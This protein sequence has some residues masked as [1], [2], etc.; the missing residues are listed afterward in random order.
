MARRWRHARSSPPPPSHS[1]L[2]RCKVVEPLRRAHASTL[3]CLPPAEGGGCLCMCVC[4]CVS[5]RESVCVREREREDCV[6][7]DLCV[8]VCMLVCVCVREKE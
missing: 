8:S 5:V 3:C 1:K 6:A 4:V 2:Q 7:L